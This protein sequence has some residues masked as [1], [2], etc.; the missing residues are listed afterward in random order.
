MGDIMFTVEKIEENFIRLEDRTKK[1]YIDV[2][3]KE[4]PTNIK[5]GD[6]L[7]LKNGKYILRK[8]LTTKIKNKV[9]NR[10]NSLM[11]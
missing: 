10:F 11:N 6:I 3:K 2:N 7:D 4:L 1:E 5:E 9:R 8:K